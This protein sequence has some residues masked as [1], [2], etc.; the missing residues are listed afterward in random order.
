MSFFFPLKEPV[1]FFPQRKNKNVL[2]LLSLN[3]IL[4]STLKIFMIHFYIPF[5][6]RWLSAAAH[7]LMLMHF[8]F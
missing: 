5:C 6:E 1:L 4:I 3:P 8:I 7:S 2:F